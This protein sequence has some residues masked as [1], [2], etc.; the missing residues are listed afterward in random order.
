MT[1]TRVGY[2]YYRQVMMQDFLEALLARFQADSGGPRACALPQ[3]PPEPPPVAIQPGDSPDLQHF[4]PPNWRDFLKAQGLIG[5][6]TL[7]LGESTSLYVFGNL[8]G[9]PRNSFVGAGRL[10]LAG[11]RDGVRAGHGPGHRQAS[12]RGGRR[13]RLPDD[14]PGA[15]EPGA[16]ANATPSSS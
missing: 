14:L 1:E 5:K 12:L 9:L 10:G 6:A 2:S 16:P 7:V 3:V 13:R 15:L 11:T 4:L 8:F